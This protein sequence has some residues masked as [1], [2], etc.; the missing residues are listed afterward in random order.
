M[1]ESAEVW[2]GYYMAG[3]HIAINRL[4]SQRYELAYPSTLPE[5]DGLGQPVPGIEAVKWENYRV[6]II[7]C[8]LFTDSPEVVA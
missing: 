6:G 1:N 5:G 3:R 8:R 4:A 2:S 7:E